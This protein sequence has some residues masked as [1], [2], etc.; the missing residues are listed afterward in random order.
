MHG[1]G[2]TRLHDSAARAGARP[3]SSW[4]ITADGGPVF[5]TQGFGSWS[6]T[7]GDGNAAGIDRSTGGLLVGADSLLGD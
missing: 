1:V 4:T 3:G 6:L 7:D 5:W 2:R